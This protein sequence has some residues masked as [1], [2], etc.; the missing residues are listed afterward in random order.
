MPTRHARV[1]GLTRLYMQSSNK[2]SNGE[3]PYDFDAALYTGGYNF[4]T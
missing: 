4:L 1:G 3:V 2:W